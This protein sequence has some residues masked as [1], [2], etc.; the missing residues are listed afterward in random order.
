MEDSG[1]FEA[2]RDG[3][4][5]SDGHGGLCASLFI[6]LGHCHSVHIV[7]MVCTVCVTPPNRRCEEAYRV[8]PSSSSCCFVQSYGKGSRIWCES[9][10]QQYSSSVYKKATG[11]QQ[12]HNSHH[13]PYTVQATPHVVPVL[14]NIQARLLLS[15]MIRRGCGGQLHGEVPLSSDKRKRL[16]ST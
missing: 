15:R 2:R 4:F 16:F 14:L 7:I 12:T 11:S 6:T 13:L 10:I 3:G 9:E 5:G 8:A 1:S